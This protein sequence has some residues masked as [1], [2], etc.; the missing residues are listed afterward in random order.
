MSWL[1]VRLGPVQSRMSENRVL[2]T[3]QM[4]MARNTAKQVAARAAPERARYRT[5]S[6]SAI[7]MATGA[8][9][10]AK[11]VSKT[12]HSGA[13]SEIPAAIA[14]IPASRLPPL[15]LPAPP[16]IARKKTP[17]ASKP[18]PSLAGRRTARGWG[19]RPDSAASTGIRPA[20]RADRTAASVAV[21]TPSTIVMMITHHGRFSGSTVCAVNA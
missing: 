4:S 19:R 9:G 8:R 10:P 16:E 15:W 5:R 6:R 1:V 12:R 13:S 11:P 21:T 14:A 3:M 20:A 2:A 17:A 18:A 7:R